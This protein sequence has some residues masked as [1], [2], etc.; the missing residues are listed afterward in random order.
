MGCINNEVLL[1]STGNFI[2]YPLMSHNG[3][4]YEKECTL[5]NESLYRTAEVNTM[6]QISYTSMKFKKKEFYPF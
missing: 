5:C 4:E 3:K 2:Q 1:Y 6:F